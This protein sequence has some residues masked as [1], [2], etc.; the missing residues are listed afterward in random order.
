MIFLIFKVIS[1]PYAFNLFIL[2]RDIVQYHTVYHDI[3]LNEIKNIGLFDKFYNTPL[4]TYQGV[5][6]I[7]LPVPLLPM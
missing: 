3:V 6:C 1:G 5:D 2:A 4:E 7:Y